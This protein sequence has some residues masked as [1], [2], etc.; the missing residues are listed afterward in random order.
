MLLMQRFSLF[1]ML[2]WLPVLAHGQW[3]S[4]S[5]QSDFL[6]VMEAFQPSAWHDGETLSIGIDIADEYYLYRHQLAVSSQQASVSLE[7]PVIPQGT[8]TTDEFMGDVYVFRDQLVF[9][10]PLSTA[11]S[12]PIRLELTFQGCADAGLCY[13]PER[14]TLEAAE[15]SPPSAFANWQGESTSTPTSEVSTGAA[16]SVPQSED[17]KFSTLISNTSLPLALGLF[18][19]AG[20][21][22]TFTPCVLPMI[23]ILSSIVVGQNPTKP[24]AFVLSASYVLG[25]A[26]TYAL[27]G[28]L[29]GLFGA[30]LNLQA[31]LQSAPVLITFAILFTLF[32][33]AMFGA[34]D[35]RVSPRIANTIDAWQ[36]R[37]QRSGPMGLAVAGALSV[38]VVSPCVTAPLAGALVFISSTGDAALGGA[39]LFALGLGMGLPLLLVGTFGTTLLPRS[40]GWMNGVKIAFG[41]LL[42]GVAIWMIERLIAPSI[43]LLLWAALAI[44][45]ALT[46]GAL[47][48]SPSQGW[49]K[50]RQTAGLMLLAW[51]VALV[52]GAAQGGSNPLRP[53]SSVTSS[54]TSHATAAPEFQ[55]INT[56][57]A[58][59]TVVEQ[60][61]QEGRPV[62][63]H[64]TADWCISC[65]LM[66]R[67]VYP[68]PNV[69]AVLNDFQLI[70][71]DVTE[72]NAQS[73]ELLNHFNLFGPPSLLLFHQGEE[74]R[75][76][77]IQGEVTAQGLTQHLDA[78]QRWQQG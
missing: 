34:F 22:L 12:G 47:N 64:F 41:L 54:G 29:M 35:L 4:S 46:I 7:E 16:L 13:P 44:G 15:T 40:G 62:F 45:S 20:I 61:A 68:D 5:N 26:V 59:Q 23:P 18:F 38:L 51:G 66:E 53:L 49:A 50:A 14:I 37:A 28:V 42:L 3:F 9:E 74:V 1:L 32:A 19:L 70:A 8:F 11:Y 77:R 36:A 27:V 31:H 43:S 39:V 72:T 63:A 30:G 25:M 48:T 67:E 52:L 21:G 76:A 17:S 69:A 56:L 78:F 65:K 60:A 6:P 73:R 33:L 55:E 58:L 71:V 75:E 24:R 2:C 57:S 10:V